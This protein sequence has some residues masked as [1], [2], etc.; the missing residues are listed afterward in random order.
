MTGSGRSRTIGIPPSCHLLT[1]L[2]VARTERLILVE[3]FS[4]LIKD[5]YQDK[6]RI[7]R[8]HNQPQAVSTAS[9]LFPLISAM[10]DD[11]GLLEDPVFGGCITL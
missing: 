6:L 5:R 3:G 1:L 9:S 2:W 11:I 10:F 7:A 8:G 4:K